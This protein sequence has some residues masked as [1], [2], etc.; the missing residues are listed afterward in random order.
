MLLPLCIWL[1]QEKRRIEEEAEAH[2]DMQLVR[3]ATYANMARDLSNEVGW[4]FAAVVIISTIRTLLD[5]AWEYT[6]I[7]L[8]NY[9]QLFE[10]DMHLKILK[11]L[12]IQKCRFVK[13]SSIIITFKMVNF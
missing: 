1:L 8:S 7:N 9:L 6:M 12:V 4:I 11:E 10:V 5:V 3:E 2:L 13:Q